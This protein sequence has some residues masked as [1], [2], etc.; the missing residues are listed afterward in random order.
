MSRRSERAACQ[1]AGNLK[2]ELPELVAGNYPDTV[3]RDILNAG[4]SYT[5]VTSHNLLMFDRYRG[6][7]RDP[8]VMADLQALL[9]FC[10]SHRT[11]VT[12]LINPPH[13]DQLESLDLLG[14]WPAFESWKRDLVALTARHSGQAG[15]SW[16][17]LWDF[18]GYDSYST[19]G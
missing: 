6:R 11:R 19:E 8:L 15:D 9:N 5:L 4:G 12:L 14:H 18:S 16:V 7:Q 13:A 2:R 1:V 17:S 10:G 3:L